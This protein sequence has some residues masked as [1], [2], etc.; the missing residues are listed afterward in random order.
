MAD[1]IDAADWLGLAA[2]PIFAGMALVSGIA[3]DGRIALCSVGQGAWP[4]SEMVLMYLLMSFF[5]LAPWVRAL[6]GRRP[7]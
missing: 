1:A 7:S 6:S 2:A 3:G 5:H 4:L